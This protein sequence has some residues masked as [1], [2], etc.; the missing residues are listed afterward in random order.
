[1]NDMDFFTLGISWYL[2][3]VVSTTLHEAAHAYVAMKLGDD[4]AYLGGQV[5]LNPMPHIEREPM[6]MFAVPLL[7]YMFSGGLMG[8]A[9]APYDP[10]WANRYPKRAAL[11]ALA[12]P[13]SNLLLVLLS[14]L[15]I[16]IGIEL[17]YFQRPMQIARS[18]E[19]VMPINEIYTALTRTLCMFF[20]LNL[21]LFF[22]NLI[23]SPPLDGSSIIQLFMP[24]ETARRYQNFIS[25]PT[26]SLIGL[27]IGWLLFQTYI[28]P[29]LFSFSI[30]ILY[31]TMMYS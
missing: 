4:T 6:G 11:M 29:S 15:A 20:S 3:F 16:H 18:T 23:P 7:L 19:L 14:G 28:L 24:E 27:I 12:G 1:M 10:S 9:S 26:N 25:D 30:K 17:G 21:L 13:L 8:W 31:P 2:V 22:F 5:S